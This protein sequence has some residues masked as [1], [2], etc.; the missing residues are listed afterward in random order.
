MTIKEMNVND[1]G[2]LSQQGR[3]YGRTIVRLEEGI[4]LLSP[5][6]RHTS[7]PLNN[8]WSHLQIVVVGKYLSCS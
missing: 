3:L 7:L 1:L 2:L 6:G 4:I 5:D 8:T